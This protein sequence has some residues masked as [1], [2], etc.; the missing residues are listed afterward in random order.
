LQVAKGRDTGVSQVTG[1]TAKISMG[2]GMQCRSR[3]VNRLASQLDFF[4]LLSFYFS[5]VGGFM[6]QV[7]LIAAVYLYIYTKLYIVF[8]PTFN[9][10]DDVEVL[11]VI[12]SQFLFQLGFLLILPI[13]MVLSLEQGMTK[14]L[15]TLFNILLRLSPFFFVFATGT[16]AYYVNSAIEAGQAKY[17]ATGRGF[18]IAH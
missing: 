11:E 5:S 4:R 6:S 2:N 1:F 15:A 9:E 13:P 7:L 18:V 14:A 3:E 8:E 12:S 16:N 17:Q 10:I